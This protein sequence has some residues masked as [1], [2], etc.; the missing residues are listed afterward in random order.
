MRSSGEAT[1][2]LVDA[3]LRL[4]ASSREHPLE[5]MSSHEKPRENEALK[6]ET[7]AMCF[8]QPSDT[9]SRA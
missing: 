9:S 3:C 4:P 2:G 8:A 7:R 6:R 1:W 5:A